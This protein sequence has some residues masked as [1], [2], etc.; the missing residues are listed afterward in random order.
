MR[1]QAT[2]PAIALCAVLLASAGGCSKEEAP[3]QGSGDGTQVPLV[4]ATA[5][6]QAEVTQTRA[7]TELGSG[8]AIGVFL[9]NPAGSTAYVPRNNVQYKHTGTGWDP[10]AAEGTGIFL[11]TDDAHLCAYYPYSPAQTTTGVSLTAHIPA[12]GETLPVFAGNVTASAVNKTV[13]FTMK[14]SYAWVALTF[15]RNNIKDDIT[16]SEFS[17][18]HNGLYK[19]AVLDI[20]SSTVT[21]TSADGSKLTFAGDIALAKNGTVQRDIVLPP[22]A[23]GGLTGGLK[24]SVKIKEYGNKVLSTTLTGLTALE[25]GYKYA[26]TITVDGTSLGV[27]S[28]EVLPWA[29]TTVNGG[30]GPLLPSPL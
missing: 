11:K 16:L 28:V 18:V 4:I 6:I 9:S 15:R 14:Q 8:S 22:T 1:I 13:N 17:L 5:G 26:V 24:V 7:V 25:Q 2:Y 10:D 19:S 20:G 29:T 27:A 12:S 3:G 21:G 23:A 30:G